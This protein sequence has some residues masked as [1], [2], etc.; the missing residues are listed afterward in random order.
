[1]PLRDKKWV[2]FLCAC[3]TS[4][5]DPCS[6]EKVKRNERMPVQERNRQPKSTRNICVYSYFGPACPVWHDCPPSQESTLHTGSV[7][8]SILPAAGWGGE[9]GTAQA[10][11]THW[12]EG[13]RGGCCWL[14]PPR[15]VAFTPGSIKLVQ[16]Y[17]S[18]S[19]NYITL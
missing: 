9:L 3:K 11:W 2:M 8:P 18:P 14:L 10:S 4:I 6:D 16:C 5:A 19:K 15:P 7:C 13:T 1:M 17:F 12:E